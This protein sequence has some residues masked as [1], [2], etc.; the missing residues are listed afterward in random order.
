MA[1][2]RTLAKLFFSVDEAAEVLGVGRTRLYALMSAGELAS[3]TCGRR[4][5]IPAEEL[6]AFAARLL[7]RATAPGAPA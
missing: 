4:R 3:V 1:E 5:L 6:E 7:E 2:H